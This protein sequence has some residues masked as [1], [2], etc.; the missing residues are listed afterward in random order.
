MQCWVRKIISQRPI[1]GLSPWNIGK[2]LDLQDV[3]C[4]GKNLGHRECGLEN[5]F[6]N[7][8]SFCFLFCFVLLPGCY[9]VSRFAE[10]L[11]CTVLFHHA[12]APEARDPTNNALSL[13]V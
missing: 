3:G 7:P 8:T 6:E 13:K 1:F 12:T 9:E 11:T 5:S 10:L 4:H 2:W